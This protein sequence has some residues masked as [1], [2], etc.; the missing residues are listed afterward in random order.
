MAMWYED[1]IQFTLVVLTIISFSYLIYR[2]IRYV[3]RFL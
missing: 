2:A 1:P 3:E